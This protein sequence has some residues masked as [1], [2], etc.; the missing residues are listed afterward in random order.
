MTKRTRYFMAASAAVFAAGLGTGLVA[1]YTGGFAPVSASAVSNELPYIPVD[2]SVVAYADVRGI[3]DSDLRARLKETLPQHEQGQRE[4]QERT[5][6]NIETD[7]DLCVVVDLE[8][9]AGLL[10]LF[11]TWMLD[12]DAI[13]AH[14][15]Q[16]NHPQRDA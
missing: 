7:I 9:D 16:S 5:G 11:E 13:L 6:I 4:F 15:Q 10:V 14:R 3:M 1:Y 8:K 12:G 2:A